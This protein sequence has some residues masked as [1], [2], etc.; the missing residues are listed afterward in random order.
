MTKKV[1]SKSEKNIYRYGLQDKLC[2]LYSD[3]E[4]GKV[5]TRL[6]KLIVSEENIVLAYRNICKN[7][8]SFTA[9]VLSTKM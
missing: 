8:G 9:G 6:M 7:K 2:Q 4:Q 5:F 1:V 3:S